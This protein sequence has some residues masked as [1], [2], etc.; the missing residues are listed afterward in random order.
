V[1]FLSPSR[2][3]S[4]RTLKLDQDCFP[5]SSFP[6]IIL[7][8]PL[9]FRLYSRGG[10]LD[11]LREPHFKKQQSP[12]AMSY[13]CA[14]RLISSFGTTYSCQFLYSTLT[15][16]KS[17]YRL[18][19]TDEHLTELTGTALIKQNIFS[20]KTRTLCK[21]SSA[22]RISDEREPLCGHSCYILSLTEEKVVK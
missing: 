5:P 22:S 11:H 8:S 4:G 3:I 18:V 16:T 9:Y 20:L 12:K 17:E 10:Q 2:R 21:V 6:F 14:Q 1:V 19:L 7:L 15:F 13:A